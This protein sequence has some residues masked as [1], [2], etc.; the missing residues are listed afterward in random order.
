MLIG[1]INYFNKNS[2]FSFLLYQFPYL[3]KHLIYTLTLLARRQEILF[4]MLI[5]RKLNIIDKKDCIE[6]LEIICSLY[7]SA[8]LPINQGYSHLF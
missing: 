5:S 7:K 6:R 2:N 1:E 3:K 8:I 4:D